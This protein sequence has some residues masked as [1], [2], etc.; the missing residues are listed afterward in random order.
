MGSLFR[1]F[2]KMFV[3][4]GVFGVG[5]VIG[6]EHSFEE[7]E[8]W[9]RENQ[10]AEE[11][12]KEE[13]KDACEGCKDAKEGCKE[14]CSAAKAEENNEAEK[15]V[16]FEFVDEEANSVA[17]VGSFND[18]NKEANPMAKGEDNVWKCTIKLAPG[19]YEYQFIVNNTDW[20]VDP[21]AE[22]AD[23]KYEG[24]NSVIEIK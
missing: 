24:K 17:L 9:N 12:N 18:W 1:M 16:E 5:Y 10:K 3:M 7:E 23:N 14:N 2:W 15:E 20:K 21:K 19:K 22:S 6:R 8:Q 13:K 4:A 11:E